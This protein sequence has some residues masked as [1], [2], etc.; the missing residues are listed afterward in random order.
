M[1]AGEA[2]EWPA[3]GLDLLAGRNVRL[4]DG[5]DGKRSDYGEL[6]RLSLSQGQNGA[7][8]VPLTMVSDSKGT[9]R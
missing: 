7:I 8:S 6:M 9:N 2:V 4:A 3:D 5:G 1:H